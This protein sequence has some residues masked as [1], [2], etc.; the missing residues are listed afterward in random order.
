MPDA[1][2]PSRPDSR[3]KPGRGD[4]YPRAFEAWGINDCHVKDLVVLTHLDVGTHQVVPIFD[5]ITAT[6]F[7]PCF[8]G[9]GWCSGNGVIF[10][11]RKRVATRNKIL[12]TTD[13]EPYYPCFL[14]FPHLET[15]IKD[16]DFVC[17]QC[18]GRALD[19]LCLKGDR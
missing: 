16:A 15:G 1:F 6:V 19:Q 7:A 14:N 13:D 11:R 12:G 17:G 3:Q 8:D 4:Q 9:I 5:M 2:L 10:V 18:L